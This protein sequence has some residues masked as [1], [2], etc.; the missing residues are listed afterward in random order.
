LPS[1]VVSVGLGADPDGARAVA[2]FSLANA[3]RRSEPGSA[4]WLR[5]MALAQAL[6]DE[7]AAVA[8]AQGPITDAELESWTAAHWLGVDRPAAFRTTHVVV[9]VDEKATEAER[10]SARTLAERIRG[11]V[12][13]AASLDEFRAKAT[14]VPAEGATVKVEDLEPV[15]AD[16]RVVRLGAKVGA[17]TGNYDEAFAQAACALDQLG[18]TSPVITSSFG[19]HVLRLV[20]I[21]PEL[22][23]S[24]DERRVMATGD[25]YDMRARKQL[26]ELIAAAR[27]QESAS[28]ERSAEEATARVSVE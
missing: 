25:V 5:Q 3:L 14:A 23:F 13:D 12:A 2:N 6:A 10:A 28:V 27:K 8:R 1:V 17:P 21:V 20:E 22:R 4:A 9:V 7:L 24:A 15:V 18:E 19:F 16:G 26:N 11:A